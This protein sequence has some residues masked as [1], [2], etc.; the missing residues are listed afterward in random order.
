MLFPRYY[1]V[2]NKTVAGLDW[3]GFG[4][5]G[6]FLFFFFIVPKALLSP[7][8]IGFLRGAFKPCV[9]MTNSGSKGNQAK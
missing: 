2:K 9:S 1:R 5:W 3:F 4:L 7:S 6:V 8:L